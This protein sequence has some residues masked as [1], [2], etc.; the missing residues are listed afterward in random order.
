MAL[1]AYRA[2]LTGEHRAVADLFDRSVEKVRS[3]KEPDRSET[4][5][6]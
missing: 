4:E 3:K 1:T 5:G 6:H 2:I